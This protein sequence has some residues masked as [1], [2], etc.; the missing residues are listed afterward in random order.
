MTKIEHTPE[1]LLVLRLW[2]TTVVMVPI[3]QP[4]WLGTVQY[5]K[6]WHF[7]RELERNP[8]L[9]TV[10]TSAMSELAG[11][12]TGFSVG[13]VNFSSPFFSVIEKAQWGQQQA[14]FVR[15]IGL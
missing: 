9:H 11:D 15:S 14:L 4:L 6:P 3:G 7:G 8:L 5:R 13:W 12:L 1:R 2:A 10:D